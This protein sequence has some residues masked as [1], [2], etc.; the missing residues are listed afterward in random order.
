MN[1]KKSLYQA[2]VDEGLGEQFLAEG[3]PKP[4]YL[5]SRQRQGWREMAQKAIDGI[6]WYFPDAEEAQHMVYA[7]GIEV[8]RHMVE[9][10][11]Q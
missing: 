11:A 4:S 7:Q 10:V 9:A 2:V 1:A 6:L 3:Q 5:L 8:L